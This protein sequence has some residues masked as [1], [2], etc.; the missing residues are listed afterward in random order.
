MLQQGYLIQEWEQM[1]PNIQLAGVKV[2]V[3]TVM[4]TELVSPMMRAVF[5]IMKLME[6]LLD[7]GS[8]SV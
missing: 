3:T 2:S 6:V 5:V 8:Y 4:L 1:A 7:R